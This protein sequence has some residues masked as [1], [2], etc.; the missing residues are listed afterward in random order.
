MPG[1][2]LSEAVQ[3]MITTS[4]QMEFIRRREGVSLKP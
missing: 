1:R 2:A 4:V 3:Q